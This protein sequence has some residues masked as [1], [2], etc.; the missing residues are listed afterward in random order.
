MNQ[1][2]SLFRRRRQAVSCPMATKP[3]RRVLSASTLT[4]C[5]CNPQGEELGKIEELMIDV[6]TGRVA[7]AVLSFGG[8]LGLGNKL[9]AVPW[10]SLALDQ[11]DKIFILNVSKDQLDQ[12]PGFDKE[13]WPDMNADEW[14]AG[15]HT[16]YGHRPYWEDAA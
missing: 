14:G 9:F 3:H 7:Y 12:A 11:D 13:N 15:I 2:A 16:H 10:Q 4:N 5:V 8:V 6:N 1:G